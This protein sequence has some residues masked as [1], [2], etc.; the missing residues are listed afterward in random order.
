MGDK[1]TCVI[2]EIL[3]GYEARII[4]KVV[5]V[6]FDTLWIWYTC[7][8]TLYLWSGYLNRICWK[9][10]NLGCAKSKPNIWIL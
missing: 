8:I 4:L 2:Y 10:L 5:F 9:S 7:L 1:I 3:I 6:R